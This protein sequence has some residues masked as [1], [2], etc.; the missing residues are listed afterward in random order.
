MVT[1]AHS[2]DFGTQEVVT[3]GKLF[4]LSTIIVS[5]IK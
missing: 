3:L 5:S 1:E 4:N 2:P